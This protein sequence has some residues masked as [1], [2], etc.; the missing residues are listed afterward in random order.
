M[1][2][3]RKPIKMNKLKLRSI[4]AEKSAIAGGIK[5]K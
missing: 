1:L 5:R 4:V 2:T 3:G